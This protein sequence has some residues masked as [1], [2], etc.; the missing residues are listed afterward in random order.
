VSQ[1]HD[2]LLLDPTNRVPLTRGRRA[3]A[4]YITPVIDRLREARIATESP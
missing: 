2:S 3:K 1:L 4:H